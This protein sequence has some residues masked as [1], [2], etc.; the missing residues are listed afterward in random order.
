MGEMPRRFVCPYDRKPMRV[1]NSYLVCKAG[2]QKDET[3]E[4]CV[5]TLPYEPPFLAADDREEGRCWPVR[6]RIGGAM[7]KRNEEKRN[8]E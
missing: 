3:D 6:C 1:I 2:E 8:K 5:V 7:R 4:S